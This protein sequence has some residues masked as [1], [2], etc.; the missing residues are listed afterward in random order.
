MGH[1]KLPRRSESFVTA[2]DENKMVNADQNYMWTY[3]SPEY[4]MLQVI[5]D[6]LFHLD[7]STD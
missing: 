2:E 1:Y 6:Y 4:P 7:I 5:W 3:T